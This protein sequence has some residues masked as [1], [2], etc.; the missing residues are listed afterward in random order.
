MGERVLGAGARHVDPVPFLS[1]AVD[2]ATVSWGIP[3]EVA[4]SKGPLNRTQLNLAKCLAQL[5]F[6]GADLIRLRP[7]NHVLL[8]SQPSWRGRR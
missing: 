5:L 7:T 6:E 8:P 4:L 2:F 3:I 1:P